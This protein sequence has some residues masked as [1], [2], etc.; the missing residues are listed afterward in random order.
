MIRWLRL[1]RMR[2][3]F[4]A[5]P[6][7]DREIFASVRFDDLSYEETA[8]LHGCSVED[9]IQSLARTLTALSN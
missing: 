3:I 4:R 8:K 2:R 5:L 9:V 6:D 7:R 1:R